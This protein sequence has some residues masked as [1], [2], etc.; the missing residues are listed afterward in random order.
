MI[1][2]GT[3]TMPRV[4]CI[5]GAYLLVAWLTA[6]AS[7]RADAPDARGARPNI[8]FVMVD[9]MGYG[10]LG[11]Y[12]QELIQM[13]HVDRMAREGIRYTNAYAGSTVCAPSRSV[14]MTGQH[15]GHTTVRGNTGRPGHGGVP[16][17][18][19]G[20]MRVPLRE[21][22]VTVADVL[23]QAGYATGIT[24]KWGLGEPG[25][26]GIP[27]RQGFDEWLGYLNQRRAHS[28][29]PEY[30]WRNE[31]K[32]VLEGNTGTRK[33]FVTEKHHTHD[34]FTD[35]ALDF[36]RR[37]GPGEAPFF[38]YLAYTVPHGVFQIPELEPY[39]RN[40]NWPEQAKVYASM[41]TRAD[42]D[43][44]RMF[45]LL[46][47]LK[48]DEETIVFFCSD[49]GAADRYEGLFNSSGPLRGRKRAMY[50]GGLRTVMVARWPGRIRA[51]TAS[52]DIWYFAD[53]L[54]T[55]AALAGAEPPEGIDGVSVLPSLLSQ[56]QPELA[57][58]PLYWEFHEG[59][60]QQ[61]ARKGD[62]KAVRR[63]H[64]RPLELFNLADDLG[65]EDNVAAEH[66]E[67]VAWFD[68]FLRE[69]RTPSANWPA[70]FDEQ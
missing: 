28:H 67:R 53:V 62:W 13:P 2:H 16:G 43:M 29:Y 22:D 70:P 44:G 9:D 12:G 38:L 65:E 51:N 27:K 19:G 63:A 55:F 57:E 54:P 30:I 33:N 49:N 42:R 5:A 59:G 21:D 36:I 61:A 25:T 1:S 8:I 17:S 23:K 11:V 41:L 34:L 24:G 48:I 32:V 56:P 6:S 46:E 15:T 52:D 10:D 60:F 31:E 26:T 35:F 39:A 47:E 69:S 45:K 3:L 7:T 18:G 4:A 40:A 50:E 68:R 58:R 20:G 14:L 37:H 66:P 64:D